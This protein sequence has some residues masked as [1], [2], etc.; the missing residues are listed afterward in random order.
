MD[1]IKN[2]RLH[3]SLYLKENQYKNPKETFKFA[4]KLIDKIALKKR[5]KLLDV[6]C[7]AGDFLKYLTLTKDLKG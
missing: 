7:A 1:F 6:G 3:D 4:S 5:V 2:K